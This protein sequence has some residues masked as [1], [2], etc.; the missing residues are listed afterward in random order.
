MEQG[1]C[2]NPIA[3]TIHLG[4][5]NRGRVLGHPSGSA[6]SQ[7]SEVISTAGGNMP[8]T[9][10]IQPPSP[11][12]FFGSIGV[13]KAKHGLMRLQEEWQAI[14]FS[15]QGFFSVH[16]SL[17]FPDHVH[18]Q[19]CRW[20]RKKPL[21]GT[22]SSMDHSIH[23]KRWSLMKTSWSQRA[24][25]GMLQH[26]QLMLTGCPLAESQN[27]Q[28][29]SAWMLLVPHAVLWVQCVFCAGFPVLWV[30]VLN[31]WQFAVGMCHQAELGRGVWAKSEGRTHPAWAWITYKLEGAFGS[32]YHWLCICSWS[33][34]ECFQEKNKHE[35]ALPES[36]QF[37]LKSF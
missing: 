32:D 1:Q 6:E 17:S 19:G 25:L 31:K 37:K 5:L 15:G 21:G 26:P 23:L 20:T 4:K 35:W 29:L 9:L 7:C 3:S 33:N 27:F 14:A 12:D 34:S 22:H 30:L 10:L 16:N 36:S 18:S 8:A 24:R 2:N 13:S 28:V 11:A